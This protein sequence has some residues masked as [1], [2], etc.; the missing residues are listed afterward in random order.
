MA[1]RKKI[2]L[3]RDPFRTREDDPTAV[4]NARGKVTVSP[5]G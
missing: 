1:K 2:A 4:R 5:M 3:A